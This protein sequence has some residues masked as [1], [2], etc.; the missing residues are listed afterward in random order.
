MKKLFFG[1][2]VAVTAMGASAFTSVETSQLQSKRFVTA[3]ITGYNPS[4]HEYSYSKDNPEICVESAPLPCEVTSS[5]YSLPNPTG[6]IPEGDLASD[7]T[8]ISKRAT[9]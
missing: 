1:L 5:T 3:Y 9:Y 4:T 8:V 2:F 7:F 6:T